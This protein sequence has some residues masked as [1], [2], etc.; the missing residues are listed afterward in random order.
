MNW[1][2]W[3]HWDLEL[4]PHLEKRM[5]QRDFTEVELRTML[6]VAN[7]YH[8][9]MVLDRWIIETRHRGRV[10]EVIVEPDDMERVLVV[11]TALYLE[12]TDCLIYTDYDVWG[13]GTRPA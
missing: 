1:P 11:I 8:P 6:A 13:G 5:V 3:W 4:T 9:D 12:T 10:W 2:A 7:G